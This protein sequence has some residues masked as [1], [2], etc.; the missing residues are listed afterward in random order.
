MG[1]L[2]IVPADALSLEVE[3]SWGFI[4][5]LGRTVHDRWR[6]RGANTRHP[7]SIGVELALCRDP[8]VP[9]RSSA[10]ATVSTRNCINNVKH[11]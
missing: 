9:A 2:A 3:E 1:S 4:H 7:V 11:P 5:C 10:G 6:R 8:F